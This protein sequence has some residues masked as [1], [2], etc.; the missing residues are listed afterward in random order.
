M[1]YGTYPPSRAALLVPAAGP[2]SMLCIQDLQLVEDDA[3]VA[4]VACDACH[5]GGAGAAGFP[6]PPPVCASTS[7]HA[8]FRSVSVVHQVADN[9]LGGQPPS[10]DSDCG[11]L[12][13]EQ[14]GASPPTC[15]SDA[16]APSGL[17][18]SVG[19]AGHCADLCAAQ[20]ARA[21][22]PQAPPCVVLLVAPACVADQVARVLPNAH[23]VATFGPHFSGECPHGDGPGPPSTWLL[24]VYSL[25]VASAD[26]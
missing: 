21:L 15:A 3:L 20:A 16:C 10:P 11:D 14:A 5:G 23:I 12:P 6:E 8:V 2:A 18:A 26:F 4:A 1:F 17:A 24:H 13:E 9:P 7:S 25:R 22:A 19:A